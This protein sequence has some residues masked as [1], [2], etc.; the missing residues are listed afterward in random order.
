MQPGQKHLV[1]CRCI[2]SQFRK[3]DNPPTHQFV[4]FSHVDDDGNV[5]TKH[6]QCNNCGVIHK[7]TDICTSEVM[8]SKEHMNSLVTIDDIKGSLHQNLVT[9]LDK[10]NADLPTWEACQYIIENKQW[11][12]HVVL[13]TDLDNGTKAGKYVRILGDSLFKVDSFERSEVVTHE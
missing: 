1:K 8:A 5:V 7:V 4:V 11:G 2:L 13:T 12:L 6:A 10:N 3:Q 9:I